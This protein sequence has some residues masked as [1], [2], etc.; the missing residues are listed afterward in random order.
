MLDSSEQKLFN[1]LIIFFGILSACLSWI[2]IFDFHF[3]FDIPGQRLST[4]IKVSHFAPAI[5]RVK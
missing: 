2:K 4:I 5:P 1:S 3:D